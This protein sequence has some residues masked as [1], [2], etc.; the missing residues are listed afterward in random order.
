[1]E[2]IQFLEIKKDPLSFFEALLKN[3]RKLFC[4]IDE[5][6]LKILE[7]PYLK[8]L[9]V[10]P[11]VAKEQTKTRTEKERIETIL[12]QE[13][14]KKNDALIAVGGGITLDIGGFIASTLL[15]GIPY[16]SIPTTLLAMVDAAIG[17]KTGIN[18]PFGKNTIGS[19]YLPLTVFFDMEF[20]STL[21]KIE[22]LNGLSEIIK[23][24][25]VADRSILSNL[26]QLD[27]CS[28]K[29]IQKSVEIKQSIVKLDFHDQFLRQILNFGHTVG[30]SI[31]MASSYNIPHGMAVFYGM[32]VESHFSSHFYPFIQ[33]LLELKRIHY[34]P[35]IEKKQLD[36]P[37][38]KKALLQDKKSVCDSIPIVVNSPL[39]DTSCT[40]IL[41]QIP[42]DSV[43]N[44]I[45]AIIDEN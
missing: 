40:T 42:L 35:K 39:V 34:Y 25:L 29:L 20:L 2:T 41:S 16:F 27:F 3:Y 4:V 14:V 9:I 11:F 5:N 26:R 13:G 36:L 30:H 38:L 1:M 19:F 15:R 21:K 17:G 12:L 32:M 23:Y 44:Q 43:L 37:T 28:Q 31:E 33:E 6:V 22:L 18:T 10:I 45:Y 7:I 8:N 24:G